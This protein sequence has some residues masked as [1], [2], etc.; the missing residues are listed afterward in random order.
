M[1]FVNKVGLS[2]NFYARVSVVIRSAPPLAAS[3]TVALCCLEQLSSEHC[4]KG[5]LKDG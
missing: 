5:R 4:C 3:N 1:Q 2:L